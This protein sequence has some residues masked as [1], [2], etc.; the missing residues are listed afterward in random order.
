M[1]PCDAE[2]HL[3]R[4][5]QQLMTR[6]RF[7]GRAGAGIGAAALGSLLNPA[8]SPAQSP[9]P[10]PQLHFAPKARRVIYL[11]MSGGPSQLDT[12]D[13]KPE[14]KQRHG[15]E[16]PDSIR[17]GQRLTTMTS[18]QSAFSCVN[19]MFDFAR[20]GRSGA[21]VSDLLPHTAS[22]VDDLCIIKTLNT[23]AIN[24]DPGITYIQTGHQQPGRPSMGAWM[25]YGLGTENANLPTFCVLI[26]NGTGRPPR[27]DGR[28]QVHLGAFHCHRRP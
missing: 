9:L 14:L 27:M 15:T 23:E 28:R 22:V 12:F 24:H 10:S 19:P 4:L 21:W 20:H 8:L 3:P 25:S 1:P 6:R 7:F 5:Y 2:N 17:Q 16:L 18:G 26:S 11:F 13:Y